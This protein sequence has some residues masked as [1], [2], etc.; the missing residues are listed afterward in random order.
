MSA[1]FCEHKHGHTEM[2]FKNS[3]VLY[4]ANLKE[5]IKPSQRLNEHVT[6]LVAELVTTG[7]E[8]V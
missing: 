2:F 3:V 1:H 4:T 7:R 6:T 5:E 8:E